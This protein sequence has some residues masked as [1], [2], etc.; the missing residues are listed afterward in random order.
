MDAS[1]IDLNNSAT[2]RHA[3]SNELTARIDAVASLD[4]RQSMVAHLIGQ[5]EKNPPP[6]DDYWG[7]SISASAVGDECAR[8]V[9]LSVWPSFHPEAREPKRRP[10]DD[11]TRV[12]FA[13]GH[14]TEEMMAGWIKAAGLPLST[15]TA[16]QIE[17]ARSYQHGF[18]TAGGHIKGFA[19]GVF[20]GAPFQATRALWENKT[21][22]KKSWSAAWRH[23]IAKAHPKYD[24]QVHLLMPYMNADATLLTALNADTGEIYAELMPIDQHKAQAASDKAVHILRATRAGDLLPKAGADG[25]SFPCKWCRF[26]DECWA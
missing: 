17:G 5:L 25:D 20:A 18:T 9:Q 1:I 16:V 13:R 2:R 11:K 12:V 15:E 8:R 21:L 14:A 23:G 24:A 3:F 4:L 6:A 26:V 19:D 10:L 22:G 7:R